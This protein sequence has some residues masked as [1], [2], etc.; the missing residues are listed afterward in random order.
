[1]FLVY[2]GICWVKIGFFSGE[3]IRFQNSIVY[4]GTGLEAIWIWNILKTQEWVTK[5]I[6]N[7]PPYHYIHQQSTAS[8]TG[9]DDPLYPYMSKSPLPL[10]P[11]TV[12]YQYTR[13]GRPTPYSYIHQQCNNPF[14]PTCLNSPLPL[15]TSKECYYE[16]SS[17]MPTLPNP[18]RMVLL[19]YF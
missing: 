5:G 9:E 15:Q 19:I 17:L 1:M 11:S 14:T 10:H 6:Y 13:N 18:D 4:S 12:C 7:S 8:T 2:A 16:L 3:N